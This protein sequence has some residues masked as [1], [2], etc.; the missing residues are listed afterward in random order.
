M[1]GDVVGRSTRRWCWQK[2][3]AVVDRLAGKVAL[4]SGGSRGQ[5]AAE[6]RL[7]ASEGAAVVLGDV[8]VEEGKEV[9]EQIVRGGGRAIFTYLDV[10][11]PD[12]WDRAVLAAEQAFGK[13]EIVINNAGIGGRGGVEDTTI[14]DWNRVIAVNQ[15]GVWLGMKH[16]IPALRRAGGGSIVNISSIYGLIG[17][18]GS[19]AYQGTKGAVRLLTK[20][21]A[22]QYA[23]ENI[24]VNSVHPG[25]ILTPMV[26]GAPQ[27]SLDRLIALTPMKRGAQ[28]EEVAY[29]VLFL[30]SDEASYVTGS[31][32]V[33]DG[34]YTAV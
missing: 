1:T 30:A 23:A 25:V 3:C 27:G 9:A 4:I 29:G 8:L 6:G 20:T 14:E 32:L 19:T 21:A 26:A 7:F 31:E 28:A 15:T 22:A 33:I 13:L 5:G 34:G 12:D 2:E 24:R 16:T 18:G 11:N 10:T 17:S